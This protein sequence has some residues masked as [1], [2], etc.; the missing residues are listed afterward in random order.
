MLNVP[1]RF[2]PSTSSHICRLIFR[3][4]LSRVMPAL[5]TRMSTRPKSLATAS[6]IASH[7]SLRD[8]VGLIGVG[9][10]AVLAH[11]AADF[12]LGGL[13]AVVKID[14]HVGPDFGQRQRGGPA[15]SARAAGHQRHL[16][17]QETDDC[18]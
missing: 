17:L 12:V 15:D 3:N 6:T 7:S 5:L 10:Y 13:V 11:L 9:L 1:V 18:P 4:L 2:T 16:T 14:G 8:D